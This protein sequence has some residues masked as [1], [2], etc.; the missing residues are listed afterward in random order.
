MAGE[1]FNLGIV[2]GVGLLALLAG[3][4]IALAVVLWSRLKRSEAEAAEASAQAA[5]QAAERMAAQAAA[6]TNAQIQLQAQEAAQA[7]AE[8]NA[9]RV[10][11]NVAQAAAQ[12]TTRPIAETLVRIE[13]H[14]REVEAQRQHMLGGLEKQLGALSRETIT[15]SQAMRAPNARGRW[16]E[17]TLRRVAEL[18]GMVAYCDFHEQ[19]GQGGQRPDMIVR[20]PGGRTLAVD[21]KVPLSAYLDAEAATDA[22]GREAALLR[23]AQQVSRHMM[24]LSAREYWAQFQPAPEMVVLF[25]AGDHFLSAALERDPDLLERA[26]AKKVLVATPVTLISVLKGV[27]YGWR[28]EKLAE[29]AEEIRRIG[30]ELYDRVR[31][32]ADAYSDAGRQLAKAVEIYNKSVA[33]WDSRLGPSLRKMHELG[34]S[35]APP[36][37]PPIV[38][39]QVRQ[40]RLPGLEPEKATVREIK[41]SGA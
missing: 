35:A 15:L 25:L 27:A 8:A 13:G 14:I 17:L 21:A 19:E 23:H 37:E 12:E 36:S 7:A 38:E 9:Q 40:P 20:L 6:Q 16:G 24:T 2:V 1:T 32:W 4:G 33:S 29:N 3:V 26:L 30:A 34:V 31:L 39:V 5:A 11:Y 41:A 22:A 28:Q 18:A 10:A